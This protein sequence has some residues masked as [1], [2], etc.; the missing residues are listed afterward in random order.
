MPLQSP[1]A[2]GSG[3]R[4]AVAGVSQ[5]LP[6]SPQ[7]LQQIPASRISIA[8]IRTRLV[9]VEVLAWFRQSTIAHATA[10]EAMPPA[11]LIFTRLC[12]SGLPGVHP[13]PMLRSGI[14]PAR[15]E[16]PAGR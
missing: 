15:R 12:N 1:F 11:A 9:E 3:C 5:K 7:L 8:V 4:H 16:R 6:V 2:T 10:R 13:W 14:I